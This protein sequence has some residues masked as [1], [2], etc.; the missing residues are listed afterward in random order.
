MDDPGELNARRT[1]IAWPHQARGERHL[2]HQTLTASPGVSKRCRAKTEAAVHHLELVECLRP[3]RAPGT[4]LDA[5][6]R[7]PGRQMPEH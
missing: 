3:C 7:I 4:R 6:L 2:T 5:G 1:L